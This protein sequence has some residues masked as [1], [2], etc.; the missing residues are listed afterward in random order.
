VLFQGSICRLK[1]NLT[2]NANWFGV[3]KPSKEIIPWYQLLT[4]LNPHYIQAYTTG[5]FFMS[6]FAREP[7]K[8]RDFLKAGIKANPWSFEIPSSLGKL[9]FDEFKQYRMAADALARSVKLVRDEKTYLSKHGSRFDE[10]QKQTLGETYLYLARSYA[11]LHEYD[12]G[13]AVC[14]AGLKEAPTYNLL[15]VEKRII[16][17]RMNE[18]PGHDQHKVES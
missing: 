10:R 3:D 2:N 7:K 9:Y 18:T 12:K 13:L 4:K 14:D 8:A 5:A 1:N 15:G 6:D 11:E 16:N 17:K